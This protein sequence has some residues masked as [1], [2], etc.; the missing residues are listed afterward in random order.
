M[1]LTLNDLIPTKIANGIKELC[2]YT[3]EGEFINYKEW[4]TTIADLIKNWINK[5][6]PF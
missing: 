2:D 3:C 6:V 5:E 1:G 4:L